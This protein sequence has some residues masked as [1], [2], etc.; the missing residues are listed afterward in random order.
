MGTFDVDVSK[1]SFVPI[2]KETRVDSMVVIL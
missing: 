1:M 2:Q